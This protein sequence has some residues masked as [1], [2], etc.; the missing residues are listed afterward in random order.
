MLLLCPVTCLVPLML[1]KVIPGPA[2]TTSVSPPALAL[3]FEG[4]VLVE[5]IEVVEIGGI[6]VLEVVGIEVFD[7]EFVVGGI[8]VVEAAFWFLSAVAPEG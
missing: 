4:T 1:R 5:D 2:S 8:E 7:F 6:D 3:L